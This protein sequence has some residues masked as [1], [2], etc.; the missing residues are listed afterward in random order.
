[1]EPTRTLQ[2]FGR[3]HKYRTEKKNTEALLDASKE[4]GLEVNSEKAK[5]MLM[6]P[7]KTG[8]KHGK[9]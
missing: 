5:Y 1:M 6:S 2:Y 9:K 4:D 8:Q 3:K 7:K